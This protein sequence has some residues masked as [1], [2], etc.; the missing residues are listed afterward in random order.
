MVEGY[1]GLY[2]RAN[3]WKH[4]LAGKWKHLIVHIRLD[5][6][7]SGVTAVGIASTLIC[8]TWTDHTGI[9]WPV[10]IY[11]SVA[12]IIASVCIL[13]WG[14][15]VGLKFFAYCWS[16]FTQIIF[17]LCWHTI[18][19]RRSV[20]CGP[21]HYFCVCP[22]GSAWLYEINKINKISFLDGQ[23]K[24]AQMMIKSEASY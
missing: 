18:R 21:S 10:L 1:W 7:P 20:I 17:L 11:M 6:Y 5:F 23:T 19:S 13:V 22:Q 15:P 12:C 2:C 9:R 4:I 8:A 16:L 3:R 24:F 14:S